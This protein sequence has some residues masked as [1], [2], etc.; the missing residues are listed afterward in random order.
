MAQMSN[1]FLQYQNENKN[2]H[3]QSILIERES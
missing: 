1:A 2:K 3:S